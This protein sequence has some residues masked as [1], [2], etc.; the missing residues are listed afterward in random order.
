MY[1]VTRY[2]VNINEA[3][4]LAKKMKV[5]SSTYYAEGIYIV[6]YTIGH[7]TFG[8]N[9]KVNLRRSYNDCTDIM[10]YMYNNGNVST[11]I[12]SVTKDTILKKTVF[13]RVYLY[14]AED[15]YDEIMN[16]YF[17]VTVGKP[18]DLNYRGF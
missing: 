10:D 8:K 2:P 1:R 12:E 16:R 5:N 6:V 9:A 17:L 3:L 7:I 4:Q 15:E 18:K 14:C 11:Y 13:G